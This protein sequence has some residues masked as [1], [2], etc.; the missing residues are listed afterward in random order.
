MR[1]SSEG[2]PARRVAVGFRRG[3]GDCVTAWLDDC[4]AR[5]LGVP[6]IAAGAN[7]AGVS[8]AGVSAAGVNAAGAEAG[9]ADEMAVAVSCAPTGLV[10]AC[11]RALTSGTLTCDALACAVVKG[12]SFV[13]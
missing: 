1:S 6:V 3:F 10:F 11:T 7:P 8:A 4:F 2:E 13:S 12:A 9:E 5:E